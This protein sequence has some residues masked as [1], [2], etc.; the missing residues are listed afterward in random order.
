[1]PT[2]GYCP[3]CRIG[4]LDQNGLCVLCGAP[5]QPSTG[6]RRVVEASVA[7][8]VGVF[9]PAVLGPA[10]LVAL[11]AIYAA[12]VRSGVAQRFPPVGRRLL[13]L[14]LPAALAAVHGDP[15]GGLLRL[16]APA[17]LQAAL[18]SLILILLVVFLRRRLAAPEPGAEEGHAFS[19]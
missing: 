6:W 9:S 11:L 14:D 13:P 3:Q 12:V 2:T 4:T 18:F 15:A 10:A 8:L 5:A 16:L 7:A 19:S 1:M 17:L